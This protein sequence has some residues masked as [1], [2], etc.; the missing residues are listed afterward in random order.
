V[1]KGEIASVEWHQHGH[2]IEVYYVGGDTDFMEGHES[3]VS[4]MADNEGLWLTLSAD[5]M[6]R[7][8]RP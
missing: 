2:R 6:R 7:W 8:V 4:D 3:V 1:L 5:D